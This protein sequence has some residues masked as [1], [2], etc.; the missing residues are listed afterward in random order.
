MKIFYF[1][2]GPVSVNTYIVYNE[3]TL[4]GFIIDPGGNYKRIIKEINDK[5]ITLKAQLLTHGHFDHCGASAQLQQD[6][7]PVYIHSFDA[8]K[9]SSEG[10]LSEMFNIEF[11]NFSADYLLNDGDM[12]TIADIEIKVLL[13]SGH[14]SGSVCFIIGNNIFSGDTLFNI[15]IGRTDFPDG[16]SD[17]L[18]KSIK[19]KLF[20][21]KG[22]YSLYP[23]HDDCSTLEYEK[24]YNPMIEW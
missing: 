2:T 14:T 6:G 9:L 17:A 20:T 3:N 11:N 1:R 18:I 23:G 5:G 10:N 13:T 7:V 8:P 19:E 16:D 21:L 22:D 4:D 24:N 12:F 15:S